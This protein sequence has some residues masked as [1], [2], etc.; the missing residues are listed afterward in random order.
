MVLNSSKENAFDFPFWQSKNHKQTV[1]NQQKKDD[2]IIILAHPRFKTGYTENELALLCNYDM[3]EGVS[4]RAT[5]IDLWDQALSNGHAVWISGNDD[6]HKI[7]FGTCGVCWNMINVDTTSTE[8]LLNSLFAGRTYATRGWVGQNMNKLVSITTDSAVYRIKLLH[9]SDSIILKSDGGK[10]VAFTINS[11]QLTYT[12][13]ESDSYLRAEIYDTESWNTYTRVYLNPVV[14]T[15]NGELIKHS[16]K[17]SVNKLKTYLWRFGLL[18]FHLL[19]LI[20]VYTLIKN[21]RK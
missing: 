1:I 21:F 8:A 17:A 16:T 18:L 11:N 2:N 12:I 7:K 15:P 13:K 4:P 20:S 6:S 3:F 5:S 10:T 9:A 19:L 14:R